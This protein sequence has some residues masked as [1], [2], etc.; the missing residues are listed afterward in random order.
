MTSTR[1]T[2][3]AAANHL[4]VLDRRRLL[5]G[6]AT[7]AALGLGAR[8]GLTLPAALAQ[9]A[10]PV[11]GEAYAPLQTYEGMTINV[12]VSASHQQF[13]PLW[14]SL[15][16]FREETGI[17]VNLSQTPTS[18][19]RQQ[20]AQSLQLGGQVFENI[21]FP[22]DTFGPSAQ[23]MTSLEPYIEAE[24]VS[25]DDWKARFVPWSVE[26]VTHEGVIKY[27]P[28]YS[29]ANA[30]AYRRDLLEDP[31]E[32]EAFESE[33]GYALPLP[34]QSIQELIDLATHFTRDG[35]WGLVFPGTGETGQN[36]MESLIF[37]NGVTYV[38][39]Q[40]HSL[41]GPAHTENQPK[42]AESAKLVQDL[43][44][45]FQ[46]TPEQVTGMTTNETTAYYQTGEAA[47]LL[48]IIYLPW[49]EFKQENVVAQIGES[50]SFAIP[51]LTEGAG[52]IPFY[53][54]RGIP[55]ASPNKDAGWEFM[56]WVMHPESLQL[57][58]RE[59]QGV[60]VPTDTEVLAWAEENNIVPTG[61]ADAIRGATF[62]R[63]NPAIPQARQIVRAHYERLTLGETSPEQFAVGS[64]AEIEQLMVDAGLV[65]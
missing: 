7:A 26:S 10:S 37:L 28:F 29:G 35:L 16:T 46:V 23:Y 25:L 38:D 32:Q 45:E 27:Y 43:I 57:S 1:D 63:M 59:G 31:A 17:Q 60:F 58:L 4:R 65:S 21:E 30:I 24:G 9:E 53:W 5:Q 50:G 13:T 62:Y 39:E 51:A 36:V 42:V 48:D 54:S 19:L 22:D 61:V 41:W 64:G 55:D 33:F 11:A 8:N 2:R 12:L 34:P 40:N 52:T 18:D 14:N 47:M 20:I 3:N 15:D 49:N 56:R 44:R 6:A